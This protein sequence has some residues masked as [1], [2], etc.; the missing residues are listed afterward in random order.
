MFIALAELAHALGQ[1]RRQQPGQHLHHPV[2]DPAQ[3]QPFEPAINAALQRERSRHAGSAETV[4]QQEAV[5]AVAR[6]KPVSR[7][8]RIAVRLSVRLLPM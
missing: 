1:V 4:D 5:L 6:S 2:G 7:W 3:A 8:R